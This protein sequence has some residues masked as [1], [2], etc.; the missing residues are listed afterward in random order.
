ML[1]CKMEIMLLLFGCSVLLQ[2][3][4]TPWTA[5]CSISLSFTI[6]QSFLKLMSIEPVMPSNHLV[7]YHPI[8]LPSILASTRV[9]SNE[10]TLCIMWPKYYSFIISIRPSNEFSGLITFRMYWFDFHAV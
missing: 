3:L 1:L 4:G 7:L 2:N 10:P 8:L 9:F 6:S 5:A